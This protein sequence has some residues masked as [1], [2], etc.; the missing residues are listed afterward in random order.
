M[1]ERAPLADPV[2]LI[3]E[4]ACFCI[5]PFKSPQAEPSVL[6]TLL[7]QIM[8]FTD[9]ANKIG[10]RILESLG[11]SLLALSMKEEPPVRDLI[12]CL[13]TEEDGLACFP[14]VAL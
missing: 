4:G 9:R 14:E 5:F 7:L 3:S 12:L 6:V 13:E 11:Y 8:V 10:Q 1:P 2:R